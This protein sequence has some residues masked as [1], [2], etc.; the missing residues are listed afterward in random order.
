MDY[1]QLESFITLPLSQGETLLLMK[2][3]EDWIAE[4][5]SNP[6]MNLQVKQLLLAKRISSCQRRW[7]PHPPKLRC[8][9]PLQLGEGTDQGQ[10]EVWCLPQSGGGE[11]GVKARRG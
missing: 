11:A 7:F 8:G 5:H 1:G 9:H 2:T 6:M 4:H 10:T 3:L